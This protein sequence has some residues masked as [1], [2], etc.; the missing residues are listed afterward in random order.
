[1]FQRKKYL[2]YVFYLEYKSI[3]SFETLINIKQSR[4]DDIQH[5][6]HSGSTTVTI[7]HLVLYIDHF[8]FLLHVKKIPCFVLSYWYIELLF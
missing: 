6:R 7:M 4:L 1:M 3:K 8:C 5:D 2:N